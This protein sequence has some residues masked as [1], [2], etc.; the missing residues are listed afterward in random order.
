[1][2]KNGHEMKKSKKKDTKRNSK[3]KLG[4]IQTYNNT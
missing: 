1:M 2:N 4:Y 3:A